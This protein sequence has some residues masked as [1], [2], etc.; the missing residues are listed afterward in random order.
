MAGT[1]DVVR[2]ISPAKAVGSHMRTRSYEV[3]PWAV[4]AN[5]SAPSLVRSTACSTSWYQ[6]SRSYALRTHLASW[7]SARRLCGIGV[8]ASRRPRSCSA[9]GLH[10]P[11]PHLRVR[12]W[13]RT[14]FIVRS[15][16]PRVC[17]VPANTCRLVR[18][19]SSCSIHPAGADDAINTRRQRMQQLTVVLL[20]CPSA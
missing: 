19:P 8:T 17:E 15:P 9:V 11:W 5:Y 10:C 20:P 1:S 13:L 4:Q 12:V 16:A 7:S 2:G 18:R 14:A 3:W 6:L